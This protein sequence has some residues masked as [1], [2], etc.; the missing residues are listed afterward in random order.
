VGREES[1]WER[2]SRGGRHVEGVTEGGVVEE[3]EDLI[4]SVQPDEASL[5]EHNIRMQVPST[6][7]ETFERG[8]GLGPVY[9]FLTLDLHT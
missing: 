7:L 3:G 6:N 9:A 2:H 1:R 5:T 8:V 4:T